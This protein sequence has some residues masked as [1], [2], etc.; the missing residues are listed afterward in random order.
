MALEGLLGTIL[1]PRGA[2]EVLQ[3]RSE[4][5]KARK[6][7]PFPV[8]PLNFGLPQITHFQYFLPMLVVLFARY[9]W[10]AVSEGLRAQILE[11]LEVIFDFFVVLC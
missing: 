8:R 9:F 7:C 5:K 1:A 4:P 2:P 6:V 10:E 3:G 11:D